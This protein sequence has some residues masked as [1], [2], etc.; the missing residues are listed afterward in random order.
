MLSLGHSITHYKLCVELLNVRLLPRVEELLEL[1]CFLNDRTTGT[2]IT[3]KKPTAKMVLLVPKRISCRSVFDE[4]EC[5]CPEVLILKRV[6][7]EV[8]FIGL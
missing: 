4:T 6:A 3:F 7:I 1:T 2:Q 8:I 5:E